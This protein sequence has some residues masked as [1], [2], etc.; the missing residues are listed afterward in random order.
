MSAGT[1]KQFYSHFCILHLS[2]QHIAFDEL[3]DVWF[4]IYVDVILCLAF[5][6]RL[7]DDINGKLLVCGECYEQD[8][9][10]LHSPC[11]VIRFQIIY[12]FTELYIV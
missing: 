11:V 3:Y 12:L 5:T 8:E 1:D 4:E 9:V 6:V 10:V 7:A 2:S